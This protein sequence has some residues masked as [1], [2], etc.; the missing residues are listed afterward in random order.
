MPSS[1]SSQRKSGAFLGSSVVSIALLAEIDECHHRLISGEVV[2]SS[3][4]ANDGAVGVNR[5][6]R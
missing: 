4:A 3:A 1:S 2:M 6:P 5:K